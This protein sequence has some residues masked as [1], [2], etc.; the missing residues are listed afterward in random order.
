MRSGFATGMNATKLGFATGLVVILLMG[1]AVL[2]MGVDK[3]D[4]QDGLQ[5]TWE[6][7]VGEADGQ[8][9]PQE[10]LK[11]GKLVIESDR[12]TVTLA[13]IGTITGVQKLDPSQE[14]K[15]IDIT[16]DSGANKGKTSLGIYE[17]KGEDFRVAFAQPGTPRPTQFA[18]TP[19]SGQWVHVWKRL[20]E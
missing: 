4:I 1:V 10:Q 9:I 19:N 18:T 7:S 13:D 14:P 11:D 2:L 12:Y 3:S 15:T 6:L 5:G 8:A 20:N 17:L 16:D